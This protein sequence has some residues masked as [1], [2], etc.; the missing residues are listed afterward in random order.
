LGRLSEWSADG[1]Q[2]PEDRLAT[3]V[4]QEYG[5][6]VHDRPWYEY[7]FLPR[8][9]EVWTD[10]PLWGEHPAR[11]WERKG[12]LTLEYGV[13][14]VYAGL[15]ALATRA[16]YDPQPPRTE[17]LFR[18]WND[19]LLPAVPDLRVEERLDSTAVVVSAG[20]FDPTRDL[21]LRLARSGPP[22]LR[23]DAI[24]GRPVT[25]FTGVAHRAWR[26]RGGRGRVLHALPLPTDSSTVRF[27]FDAPTRELLPWLRE[28][29]QDTALTIDH[30]YD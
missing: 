29:V 1:E 26:P 11:T 7:R 19:S 16:A 15:I 27:F 28:L 18:R 2:T 25:G 22:D 30:V 13:K 20:R 10:L 9:W 21:L 17:L 24:A 4:A 8:L 23:V 5:R 3:E 14:A 12:F 6:F